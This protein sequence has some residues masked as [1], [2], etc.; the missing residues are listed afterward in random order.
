ML[1]RYRSLQK[2]RPHR[3]QYPCARLNRKAL[4]FAT[5]SVLTALF[6]PHITQRN[7]YYGYRM[8]KRRLQPTAELNNTG[9]TGADIIA[10][11]F[12]SRIIVSE[13]S[14]LIYCP[15]PKAA[16]SNW[17]YLIRKFEGLPDYADLT[18]AHNVNVSG[19][20]YLSDYSA[21]EIS[22]LIRDPSFF[23]F[24]FVRNP[25]SRIVSCYMDKFR[26]TDPVYVT[27]EYRLFLAQLFHWHYARKVDIYRDP[28][29]S[30]ETFVDELLKQAPIAMN[31]HWM[32]QTTHCGIGIMPYDFVGRMENLAKDARFVLDRL[33]K[34]EEC[35]PSQQEIGFPPSG[36]SKKMED[37]L[38]TIDLRF[39]VRA[40]YDD[41]FQMLGYK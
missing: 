36:A 6:L 12:A 9:A 20:R 24:I 31:A 34:F 8:R 27:T 35:F 11:P 29:P 39:K 10:F 19:L 23:K 32:P 3:R 41:D 13:V 16:N 4:L 26:N 17:K 7:T 2:R 5:C 28:R 21:N 33:G 18:K 14:R 15:I 38:Y 37:E 1:L 40:I 25:Y 22:Q 30:F